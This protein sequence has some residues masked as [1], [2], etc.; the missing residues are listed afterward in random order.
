MADERTK[1]QRF[2]AGATAAIQT[3][4]ERKAATKQRQKEQ[5]IKDNLEIIDKSFSGINNAIDRGDRQALGSGASIARAVA[6]QGGSIAESFKA[7]VNFID[8]QSKETPQQKREAESIQKLRE[9]GVSFPS[10]SE[11]PQRIRGAIAEAPI[12]RIRQQVHSTIAPGVDVA[13]VSEPLTQPST[14]FV[15][16]GDIVAEGS[17]RIQQIESQRAQEEEKVANELKV[18]GEVDAQQAKIRAKILVSLRSAKLKMGN[19]LRSFVDVARRTEQLSG[20]KPGF[21]AG[22]INNVILDPLQLNEFIRGF[23]GGLVEVATS[24]GAT[25]IPGAR[26]VRLVNVFKKTGIE[27]NQRMPS[28]VQTTADSMV[29][30]LSSDVAAVPWLYLEEFKDLSDKDAKSEWDKLSRQ[31]QGDRFNSLEPELQ[32]FEENYRGSAIGEILKTEPQLFRP[33]EILT[34]KSNIARWISNTNLGLSKEEVLQR[35]NSG[36]F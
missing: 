7:G 32:I 14:D 36:E 13:P 27:I 26:A 12:S 20:I 6:E 31:E 1:F 29:N 23:K 8:L 24:V 15:S 22:A 34:A 2:I 11:P 28:A 5:K 3:P 16:T 10:R 19:S 17:R 33:E 30:S 25:A 9:K 21:I 4:E 35:V 18:Q